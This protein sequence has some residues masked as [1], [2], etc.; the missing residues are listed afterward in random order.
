MKR[1]GQARELATALVMLSNPLSSYASGAAI[2]TTG[3][4]SIL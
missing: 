3:G 2:A 4:K 1:P